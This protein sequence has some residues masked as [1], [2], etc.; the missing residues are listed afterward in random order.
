MHTPTHTSPAVGPSDGAALALANALK[1][2]GQSDA[3]IHEAVCVFVRGRRAEAVK[4]E[5]VLIAL[6]AIVRA[7]SPRPVDNSLAGFHADEF[8]SRCVTWCIEE[9]FRLE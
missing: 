4:P 6:K 9:Y 8:V 2:P 5:A 3:A 1:R 7:A